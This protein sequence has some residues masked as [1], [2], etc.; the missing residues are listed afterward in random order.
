MCAI[1]ISILTAVY[2][3]SEDFPCLIESLAKQTDR[4]FEWVVADGG[5]TDNTLELLESASK[6][7]KNLVVNSKEDCGIYD[8]LNRSLNISTGD[9]YLV[10]GA[11]DSFEIDAIKNF[12]EAISLHFADLVV[13]KI[14]FGSKTKL[15]AMPSWMF[16]YGA[17]SKISNHAVGLA[18]KKDLHSEFGLYDVGYH[19]YADSHFLHKA[20]L[21]GA[22]VSYHD[23]V[24]GNYCTEGISNMNQMVSFCE[25]FRSQVGNGASWPMQLLLFSLRIAKWGLMGRL[26]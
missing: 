6:K 21:G 19:I 14:R 1:K 23:F 8:A 15:K 10:A 26:R 22:V 12:K 25:Q 9:Y 4:D 11:D 18:I 24:S 17:S 16:L 13:A 20:L 2:N 3:E 7:F 5:S